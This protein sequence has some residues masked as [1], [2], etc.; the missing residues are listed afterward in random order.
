[1]HTV[2]RPSTE[3]Y[4]IITAIVGSLILFFII[5]LSFCIVCILC[6]HFKNKESHLGRM[7][8]RQFSRDPSAQMS[9]YTRREPSPRQ[10]EEQHFKGTDTPPILYTNTDVHMG[11]GNHH[12]GPIV[13]NPNHIYN[14]SQ[15][16][17]VSGV[18]S[19]SGLSG[20]SQNHDSHK[21]PHYQ[22]PSVV[23]YEDTGVQLDKPPAEVL[24]IDH[25]SNG[26]AHVTHSDQATVMQD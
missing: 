26:S 11:N 18:S 19:Y 13:N 4:Y 23:Y 21:M 25:H 20:V 16:S 14:I 1:M 10:I 9:K 3:D 6:Y 15:N 2:G 12:L 22:E 5:V 17:G 8:R 24:Q 7:L